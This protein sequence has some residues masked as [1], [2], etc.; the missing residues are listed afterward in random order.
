M[1]TTLL[2]DPIKQDHI[3]SLRF[4]QSHFPAI[5]IRSALLRSPAPLGSGICRGR[6][7]IINQP[8]TATFSQERYIA[9]HPCIVLKDEVKSHPIPDPEINCGLAA[10]LG[11]ESQIPLVFTPDD[12]FA[13]GLVTPKNNSD[14]KRPRVLDIPSVM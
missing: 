3:C 5:L 7:Q 8:R 10:G 14:H 13:D 1:L 4:G 12:C 11:V 6:N 2:Q 9:C